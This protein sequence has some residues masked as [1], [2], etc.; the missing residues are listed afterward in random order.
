MK[1]FLKYMQGVNGILLFVYTFSIL[2]ISSI[3]Y[4]IFMDSNS[5]SIIILNSFNNALLISTAL[6]LICPR[7]INFFKTKELRSAEKIYTRKEKIWW[8][9]LCFGFVLSLFLI[10]YATYYPG[11]FP[12]DTLVQYTQ[13][14]N[15]NYNDW[16]PVLQ[17]ILAI[18]IP[19]MLTGGWAGSLVLF[20]IMIFAF[21]ISYAVCSILTY[22]NKWYAITAFFF[23]IINP[24]TANLAIYLWKDTTFTILA[25][26]LLTFAMHIYF[27]KGQWLKKTINFITFVIVIVVAT[28]IRHNALLFTIPLLIAVMF[29]ISKKRAVVLLLSFVVLFSCIKGPLYTYLDVEKPDQRQVETLGLPINVIG[30]VVKYDYEALDEETKAFADK[31]ASEEGWDYYQYGNYNAVK[32]APGVN[33]NVIEEYGSAKVLNMMIKCIV[34]S[35][36]VALKGLISLTEPV[37]A[38]Y[39][40]YREYV[41]GVPGQD[42][43][44]LEFKGNEFLQ[45]LIIKL[46]RIVNCCFPQLFVLLG[47]AHLFLVTSILSKCKLNKFKDWKKILLILPVFAYNFGSMFAL[48]SRYDCA[49]FFGYTFIIL[50]VLIVILYSQNEKTE[51]DL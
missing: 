19:L 2:F 1:R 37:Y 10:Y 13:T 43:N 50:P 5:V 49:R 41:V 15:G 47:V 48:T 30:A 24:N 21:A 40:D 31:I 34:A 42:H 8:S 28:I 51:V 16:H 32:Y 20:Q 23:I 36:M 38:I 4:N 27:T 25:L 45:N 11:C 33:N 6:I 3:A 12:T 22:T 46:T 26:L 14:F 29:F 35:P 7:L 9:I 18:K 44:G 39:T 17:T